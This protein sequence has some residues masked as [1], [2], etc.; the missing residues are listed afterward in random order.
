M[1]KARARSN[2]TPAEGEPTRK[3]KGAARAAAAKPAKKAQAT[4]KAAPKA[5]ARKDAA[6]PTKRAPRR[7]AEPAA[8]KSKAIVPKAPALPTIRARSEWPGPLASADDALVERWAE[9]GAKLLEL[10]AAHGAKDHEYRVDLKDGRFVWVDPEGRVSA[11]ARALAICSYTPATS[12]LTMAWAD[13]L[14]RTASIARVDGIPAEHDDVDEERAWRLAIAAANVGGADYVYRVAA[15]N[16]WYFLALSAL[17]WKPVRPSFTPSTP[18]GFVLSELAT[19]RQSLRTRAEPAVVVRDRLARIGSAFLQE[20][21]YAYRGTD[22]VT[23]LS[24]TGKRL[25]QLARKVPVPSF[26][27]VAQGAIVSEWLE[28]ELAAELDDALRMLEDEWRLFA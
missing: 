11:E 14:L 13:P 22:W 17:S 1:K 12:S 18:V 20:A 9:K 8:K 3:A 28:A 16:L 26:N 5:K 10:L 21:E 4:K 27:T 6:S 24:R 7:A 2:A 15:P 23:R 25:L 19:C